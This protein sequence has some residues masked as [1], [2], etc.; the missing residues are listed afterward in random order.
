MDETPKGVALRLGMT[1]SDEMDGA[2]CL[3]VTLS[4][5]EAIDLSLCEEAS[6]EVFRSTRAAPTAPAT[7]IAKPLCHVRF[8][9]RC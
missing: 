1:V 7:T 4:Q 6:W 2:A 5:C 8:P 9:L 3:V